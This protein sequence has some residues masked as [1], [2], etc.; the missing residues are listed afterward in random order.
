MNGK[1]DFLFKDTTQKSEIQ[2][3]FTSSKKVTSKKEENFSF[4]LFLYILPE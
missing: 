1:D 4:V 2:F 3:F